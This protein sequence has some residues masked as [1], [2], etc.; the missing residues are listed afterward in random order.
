MTLPPW[1]SID[2]VLLDMDGTLLDRNFDDRFWLEHVPGA[3]AARQGMADDEARAELFRVYASQEGTLNWTD[4]DYW[5]ERLELD[6][7]ALKGDLGHLVALHPHVR[8]FLT[9][10]R[11]GR[12]QV[13]L[14]TNAHPKTLKFKMSKIDITP[15][16][17]G[18]LTSKDAG[19]PKEDPAFW[20]L[21]GGYIGYDRERTL[22]ADDTVAV[23]MAARTH[24][25]A[26]L[27][28]ISRY[29]SAAPPERS[30]GFLSV[31]DFLPVMP[32][33]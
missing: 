11:R 3:Y 5:S 24:G 19:F 25:I 8:D 13:W 6:I 9:S 7:E 28:H 21:A 22:L 12:K 30:K 23:L 20:R 15:C 31:D 29:S 26:N 27:L 14:V 17:N 4:I 32:P 33:Y 18:I 2:T 16:F 1:H 10:L